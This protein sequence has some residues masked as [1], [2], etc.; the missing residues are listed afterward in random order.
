MYALRIASSGPVC[1]LRL[2]SRR[3]ISIAPVGDCPMYPPPF[4]HRSP[5]PLGRGHAG[6]QI[7]HPSLPKDV[8]RLR[9]TSMPS[10][11][12]SLGNPSPLG[13]GHAGSQIAHHSTLPGTIP[14]WVSDSPRFG[15]PRTIPQ[16]VSDSLGC[17]SP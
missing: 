14:Q 3:T 1:I 5:P 15:S 9:A 12:S 8:L 17:T 13:R 6:S 4:C 7:A 16:W 10:D 2:P 11:S